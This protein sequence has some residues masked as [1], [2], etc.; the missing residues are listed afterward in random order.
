[1]NT[2]NYLN[3]IQPCTVEWKNRNGSF[4]TR[5]FIDKVEASRWV[6]GK[7]DDP[8]FQFVSLVGFTWS[9]QNIDYI[10]R[11]ANERPNITLTLNVIEL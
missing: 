3:H 7:L 1:M 9:V 6:V 11:W 5:S 8:D 4:K 2:Q 10:K